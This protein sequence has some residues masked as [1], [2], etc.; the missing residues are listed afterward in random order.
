M[1]LPL[2][3]T[4]LGLSETLGPK[5]VPMPAYQVDAIDS[6]DSAEEEAEFVLLRA[7][8][9]LRS[10]ARP[11]HDLGERIVFLCDRTFQNAVVSSGRR[12]RALRDAAQREP[13]RFIATVAIIAFV[14]GFGTRISRS[15]RG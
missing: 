14:V 13:L 5:I 15:T 8:E 10:P 12:V 11:L 9:K 2:K 6:E 4:A 7:S 3:K 1:T